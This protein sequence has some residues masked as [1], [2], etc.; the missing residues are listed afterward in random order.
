MGQHLAGQSRLNLRRRTLGAALAVAVVGGLAPAALASGAVASPAAAAKPAAVAARTTPTPRA[1]A[2]TSKRAAQVMAQLAPQLKARAMA[3]PKP[4][5]QVAA[6]PVGTP[7]YGDSHAIDQAS[8]VDLAANESPSFDATSYSFSYACDA[9][10]WTFSV[11]AATFAPANIGQIQMVIDTDGNQTDNMGCGFEFAAVAFPQGGATADGVYPLTGDN[12]G[13]CFLSGSTPGAA[14]FTNVS[15]SVSLTFPWSALTTTV[16]GVANVLPPSLE[17]FGSVVDTTTPTPA[18][19]LVPDLGPVYDAVPWPGTYPGCTTPG[20]TQQVASAKDARQGPAAAAALQ[21]AG[22]SQVRQLSGGILAFA[23]DAALAH[24]ALSKAGVDA[25]VSP[26]RIYTTQAVS[27]AP[28][29][30][31]APNDPNL[32]AQWGLAATA[33]GVNPGPAWAITHGSPSAIVADIDT[34]ING[35]LPDFLNKTVAGWDVSVTPP[36][37]IPIGTNDDNQGHGTEVAGVIAA[38]TDNNTLVASLGWDI[39]V[40]PIKASNTGS[41]TSSAISAGIHWAADH[42]AKVVNLSLGGPCADPTVSDAINYADG[43]GVMV[44]A[45]AGNGAAAPQGVPD[46][47]PQYNYVSHPAADAHVLAVGALGSDGLRAFYSET[48]SYVGIAAPGGSAIANATG[49]DILLLCTPGVNGCSATGSTA[50]LTT[51]AGTSFASPMVA[52]AAA[53]IYSVQPGWTPLQVAGQLQSTAKRL[54]LPALGNTGPTDM[55]YGA[56]GLNAGAAVSAANALVPGPL[57]HVVLSPASSSIVAGT[58]QAYTA[59]GADSNGNVVPLVGPTTYTISPNG[60]GTGASCTTNSCTAT[61]TGPY[62]VTATNS[63][64]TGTATLTFTIGPLVTMSLSPPVSTVGAATAQAYTATGADSFGNTADVTGGTTFTIAP[65][66]G[67][68][69][70]ICAVNSCSATSAATYTVT[71]HNGTFT[72]TATLNVTAGALDH[73]VLSPPTMTITAGGN[74]A[75][76]AAGADI[77]GNPVTLVGTTTYTIAP[78]TVGTGASCTSSTCGATAAGSYTVTGT[79]STKTGTATLTVNAAALD[80]LVLSPASSTILA[81]G[82]QPYT[83]TGADFYGNPVTLVGTTTYTIAPNTVGTGASCPSNTCTATAAGTYTVTGTNT[84]KTG[85]ATLMVSNAALDHLVI[86]PSSST[87]LAGVAETY[88]ATGVDFYGNPVALVGP[89]TYT[90]APAGASCTSNTCTGTVVGTYTVTGTNSTRTGTATLTVNAAALDHLVLSPPSASVLAGVGQ[91]YTATGADFYGNTVA[92]V[93]TTTYG[94]TPNGGTTGATCTTSTCQATTSQTYTVTGT[95]ATK[96]G[97]ATL[98]VGPHNNAPLIFRN[99]SWYLRSVLSSGSADQGAFPFGSPGD[100][101]VTGDWT[102]SGHTGIGVFR[103]GT[104]YLRNTNDTGPADFS[105]AFGSPGDVPVTGDWAGTGTTG[106]GVFRNGSWYLRDTP[107]TGGAQ[108]SFQFAGTGDVPVTGDWSG[109]GYAGIGVYRGGN[110]YLRNTATGGGAEYSFQFA[111]PGDV[112]VTGDWDH[113]GTVTPGVVRNGTWYLRNAN[114]TGAA[115][116]GSFAYGNPSDIPRTWHS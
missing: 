105:F 114:T 6:V 53:L 67:S 100:V 1:Q 70:A 36:I 92:L 26:D 108:R 115:D 39:K 20:I 76:T 47:T 11:A 37:A 116:G 14:S 13:S 23:G 74:Q 101:P 84:G 22:F 48:G 104:W 80:H 25:T 2:A 88:S 86:S 107:T 3:T 50:G 111:G 19:D 59:A 58:S 65:N 62:T 16:N 113:N 110:W 29:L 60:A 87:R 71:G 98:S 12:T 64:K 112:P 66:G 28:A 94:I 15:P 40:M 102:G 45:A 41:L 75:Y 57:D 32:P 35:S 68:T 51:G 96:T 46:A 56:G 79:N 42:G 95:N 78:N 89:T 61:K 27:A 44:V 21:A 43:L 55:A 77:Y 24:A 81:G 5:S 31:S 99:G 109:M 82:S 52:A 85:T 72:P 54:G 73:L 93:G 30:S 10:T 103:N 33:P 90:I 7:C 69:G 34:G 91:P 38:A 9:S 63:A 83:A 17:W 106:I 18:V 4:Q 97:T 8:G 49:Q